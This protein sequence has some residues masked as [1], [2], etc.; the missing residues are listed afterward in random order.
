VGA[1]VLDGTK[2]PATI[3]S[4][5]TINNGTGPWAPASWVQG[6][7]GSPDT[8]VGATG[9]SLWLSGEFVPFSDV[10]SA[11]QASLY[12]PGTVF[13]ET[14]NF[15]TG[16][17]SAT[18][19][20]HLVGGSYYTDVGEG[21]LGLGPYVDMVLGADEYSP[22]QDPITGNLDPVLNY[23]GAGFWP[24]DSD[25]PVNFNVVEVGVPEP[26]TLSLLGFGLAGLLIRRRK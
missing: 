17:G 19:Y 23:N 24:V 13:S 15:G 25:D 11:A 1:L 5:A 20:I 26:A 10:L 4:T 14:L 18:G 22:S 21:D 3:N 7:S 8:Y 12:T 6:T 2:S 16:N 9:G